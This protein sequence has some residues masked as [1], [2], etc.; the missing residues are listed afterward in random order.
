VWASGAGIDWDEVA[1]RLDAKEIV[2]GGAAAAWLDAARELAGQDLPAPLAGR[3]TPYDLRRELRL[4]FAV[5][6]R[7]NLPVGW[8]KALAWW[9]S[10]MARGA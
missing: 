8:G 2:D 3:V 5:L 10:E 7:V 4:R 1:R 9:S 6:R